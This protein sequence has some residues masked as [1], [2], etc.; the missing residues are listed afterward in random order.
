MTST[1]GNCFLI[2]RMSGWTCLAI[3]VK[4]ICTIRANHATLFDSLLMFMSAR[5][6]TQIRPSLLITVSGRVSSR[7]KQQSFQMFHDPLRRLAI[8]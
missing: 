3:D 2:R 8:P 5:W 1:A 4:I 6:H 7:C